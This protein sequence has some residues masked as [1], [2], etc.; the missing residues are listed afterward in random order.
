LDEIQSCTAPL[1]W[2]FRYLLAQQLSLLADLFSP[3]ATCSVVVSVTMKMLED[4]VCLVRETACE[5]S[6]ARASL[7]V[8]AC[9]FCVTACHFVLLRAT[10]C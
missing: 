3:A 4:P 5:V 9:H 7:C 8:T 6:D 1:N 10:L 2:R